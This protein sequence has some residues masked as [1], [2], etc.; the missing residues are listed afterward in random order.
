MR[1]ELILLQE[2]SRDHSQE[3]IELVLPTP[4]FQMGKLR[5]EGIRR[6]VIA[7][8]GEDVDW[9]TAPLLLALP[10]TA[11][12]CSGGGGGLGRLQ[13]TEGGGLP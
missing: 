6:Q 4:I 11:G 9:P 13:A 10:L 3:G 8:V 7:E 12:L 1:V 2:W 5:P